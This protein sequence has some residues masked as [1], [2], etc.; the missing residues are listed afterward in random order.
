MR[1]PRLVA[2]A[3]ALVVA[4]T[5]LFS[6]AAFASAAPEPSATTAPGMTASF[7]VAGFSLSSSRPAPAS[8]QVAANP[9]AF[10]NG[11]TWRN[12]VYYAAD[13]GLI[14]SDPASVQAALWFV[15]S[16]TW[17]AGDHSTAQRLVDTAR[18]SATPAST[19]NGYD[20]LLAIS[21]GRASATASFSSSSGSVIVTNLQS[22]AL[23]VY[24]PYGTILVG[25]DG[26]PAYAIFAVGSGGNPP[27]ATPPAAQPTTTRVAGLPTAQP[28]APS[29]TQPSATPT[30]AN[31]GQPTATVSV[32]VS[33][34]LQPKPTSTAG[35][36]GNPV[37]PTDTA[38]PS[39]QSTKSNLATP[40]TQPSTPTAT[41]TPLLPSTPTA[42]TTPLLPS[43]PTATTTPLL[44][45]TPTLSPTLVVT[46]QV[47][48]SPA[49][50]VT[51]SVA[52]KPQIA[53]AAA[54]TP[55]STVDDTFATAI[56]T[57]SSGGLP[58]ELP[59]ILFPTFTPNSITGLTPKPI[60]SATSF[61]P[62]T[63]TPAKG[64]ATPVIPQLP[65]LSGTPPTSATG[66]PTLAAP[67]EAIP[68]LPN[69]APPSTTGGPSSGTTSITGGA[70]GS[71]TASGGPAPKVAP[72][73]GEQSAWPLYLLII[74]LIALV[75]GVVVI[76]MSNRTLK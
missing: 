49:K 25:A 32:T 38:T 34:T 65:P 30:A 11:P 14:S 24:L 57:D 66:K 16:G 40:S 10:A 76:R 64:I 70:T 46:T 48:A 59:T 36:G 26:L 52:G 41:T 42:T 27:S 71:G 28:T 31:S 75:V 61:F 21:G 19:A 45:S 72:S 43:T 23:T 63:A 2:C 6:P 73:T 67:T 37:N 22:T 29:G 54:P 51:Q 1:N 39:S 9:T 53:V 35:G 13:W 20:L 7:T 50:P 5:L 74:G 69:Q 56:P 55:I 12:I 68:T 62:P 47:P 33:A 15:S 17:P 8:V 18:S 60:P 58:T 44:P 4:L 3:L